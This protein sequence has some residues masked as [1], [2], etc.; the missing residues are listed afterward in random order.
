MPDCA[1]APCRRGSG[2]EC[3]EDEGMGRDGGNPQ[4][5]NGPRIRA[6]RRVPIH[7]VD[8][9]KIPLVHPLD[10][11]AYDSIGITDD[12]AKHATGRPVRP[13]DPGRGSRWR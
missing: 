7:G 2:G 13:S 6:W 9:V 8:C 5:P 1:V 3:E 4:S 11:S 10:M 12:D